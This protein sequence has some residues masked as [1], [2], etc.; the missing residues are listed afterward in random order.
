MSTFTVR[1]ETGGCKAP[2]FAQLPHD[3]AA[4]P[5]LTPVDVRVVTALLFWARDK[6]AA[7]PCDRS[8]AARVGRS[9]ST[10][11]RALRKLQA[12][13]LVQRDK[14]EPSDRNRTGRI[15]RLIWRLDRGVGHGC[16]ALPSAAADAP[17]SAVTDEGRSERERERPGSGPGHGSPSRPAGDEAGDGPASAEDIRLWQAWAEGG[18]HVLAGIGR[19]ALATVGAVPAGSPPAPGRPSDGPSTRVEAAAIVGEAGAPPAPDAATPPPPSGVGGGGIG[20]GGARVGGLSV[21]DGGHVLGDRPVAAVGLDQDPLEEV[22]GQVDGPALDPPGGLGVGGTGLLRRRPPVPAGA[23]FH[24]GGVVALGDVLPVRVGCGP[25]R[26]RPLQHPRQMGPGPEQ[27]KVTSTPR[28][29]AGGTPC[30]RSLDTMVEGRR[31]TVYRDRPTGR[32]KPA[33]HDVPGR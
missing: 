33:V 26:R 12:L 22:V 17:R 1:A 18:N 3:I 32:K 16:P 8:I 20:L 15:I 10:V 28:P 25:M 4:D 6:A 14:V 7:W 13:G 29:G 23:D 27:T 19:A 9:V 24:L 21:E 5:R 2:P 30:T 31:Y 11:Q